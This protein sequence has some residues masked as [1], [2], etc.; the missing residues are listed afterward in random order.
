MQEERGLEK[1]VANLEPFRMEMLDENFEG[2]VLML[3]RPHRRIMNP[4]KKLAKCGVSL[5]PRAKNQRI[6][7]ATHQGLGCNHAAV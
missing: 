7:K 3:E 5:E 6:R 1:W 2:E 4:S